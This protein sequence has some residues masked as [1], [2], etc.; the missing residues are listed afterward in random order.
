MKT[1]DVTLPNGVI[2]SDVPEN[3]TMKDVL[4]KALSKGDITPSEFRDKVSNTDDF[5]DVLGKYEEE[6]MARQIAKSGEAGVKTI[7]AQ[8]GEIS[9]NL[10]N[11]LYDILPGDYS[12]RQ[13]KISEF[14]NN[15]KTNRE[16][17]RNINPGVSDLVSILPYFAAPTARVIPAIAGNAII[18]GAET[19]DTGNAMGAAALTAATHGVSGALNGLRT[20]YQDAKDTNLLTSKV[21]LV[22]RTAGRVS[23]KFED[24]LDETV[25]FMRP[26]R[27]EL[28]NEYISNA[29]RQ[30]SEAEKNVE[31]AKQGV[32][33]SIK[34]NER[35][36]NSIEETNNKIYDKKRDLNTVNSQLDASKINR[37]KL[38]EK[39][40]N[41]PNEFTKTEFINSGSRYSKLL[42]NKDKIANDL[43]KE[44]FK[45]ANLLKKFEKSG[46]DITKNTELLNK[47]ELAKKEIDKKY[48]FIHGDSDN[49]KLAKNAI[50]TEKATTKPE[51][52]RNNIAHSFETNESFGPNVF[53]KYFYEKPIPASMMDY[54][55]SGAG[56]L[57]ATAAAFKMGV[58]IPVLANTLDRYVKSKG[59][60]IV[61][62]ATMPQYKN[63]IFSDIIEKAATPGLLGYNIEQ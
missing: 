63:N 11:K 26:N 14:V 16:E 23:N 19:G 22:E 38:Y 30:G 10:A 49:Y 37:D 9:G 60:V 61:D 20:A 21:N 7:L 34:R 53:G 27:P 54:T 12:E 28:A 35:L 4:S 8:S 56:D 2:Y 41:N 57:L 24:L 45:Y 13:S 5:E 32:E 62:R 6:D 44:E 17:A 59:N 18:A 39:F 29:F 36:S 46:D 55:K 48:E 1:R 51:I 52:F 43:K 42:D 58:P 3:V 33:N 31:Y 25:P 15:Q 47:N 40:M 50:M